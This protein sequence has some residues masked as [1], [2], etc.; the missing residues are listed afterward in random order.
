MSHKRQNPALAR[1]APKDVFA[2]RLD[3]SEIAN[4]ATLVDRQARRLLARFPIS[5]AAARTVAELH[6]STHRAFA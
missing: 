4:P 6:Y 3:T 2:E 1:R 5:L